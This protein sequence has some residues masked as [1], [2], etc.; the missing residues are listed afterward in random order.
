MTDLKKPDEVPTGDNLPQDNPD[1]TDPSLE[2]PEKLKG[3]ESDSEIAKRLIAIIDAANER[4][5]PLTRMIH[6]NTSVFPSQNS[7]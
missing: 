4:I 3:D 1:S 5:L 6:Q 2:N 7:V